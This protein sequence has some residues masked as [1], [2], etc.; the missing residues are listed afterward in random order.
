[1]SR[2]A[3]LPEV[4]V[5][6][7]FCVSALRAEVV[8]VGRVV[9]ENNAALGSATVS[10]VAAG[11]P[12]AAAVRAVCDPTGVFTLNLP[13]PGCYLVTIEKEG[14]FRLEH[15]AI[16]LSEG[17]NEFS[18]TLNRVREL[19]ESVDVVA[20][21]PPIDFDRASPQQSVTGTEIL[22]APYPN[23][24][25]LKNA[26]RIVPGV[27]Q[28]PSGRLHQHGGD[29]NQTLYILDGFNISDPLTGMFDT[30]LSVEGVQSVDVASGSYSA[31]YGKGSVGTISITTP[32]GSDRLR[33]SATNF[34]PG[35]E[36]S[37]GVYIGNWTPR[38]NLSGPI[39]K[40]RAWFSD[41][42]DLQ[43]DQH[44]VR[45]LPEGQDR[46]ASWR[47]SNLISTQVN[48]GPSN[49]LHAGFLVNFWT[50][51]LSGLSPLDPPETTVDR[52]SRQWF[53]YV[54]DHQYF[55][56]GAMLEA[57][58][59]ANRTF[60]RE[61]PQGS[62]LYVLLPDGKRGNYF[63]DAV[64]QGSRDQWIVNGF[65]PSFHL[66]GQH[67]VKAGLDF[68]WL[69][70]YQD[71]HRT[72]F[73]QYR[74]DSSVSRRVTFAGSGELFRSNFEA[75]SYVQDSWR[76]RPRLLVELGL[77]QDWDQLRRKN[78]VSPRLGVAWQPP[79]LENTKVSASYAMLYGAT[80]L[81]LFTRHMAKY[82]FSTYFDRAGEVVR[83]PTLNYFTIDNDRLR[84]PTDRHWNVSLEQR[85]PWDFYARA[86]Y[87]RRRQDNAFTYW[88]ELQGTSTS[89]VQCVNGTECEVEGVFN[90]TN[91]RKDKYD[92]VEM[93]LRK[94][95]RGQ[96]TWMGSY[97]WSRAR[98]NSAAD[99]NIDDPI[100]YSDTLGPMPWDTPNRTISW[101]Y[102]PLPWKNWA[103]AYLLE[104]RDGFPFTAHDDDGNSVGGVNSM[105]FPDYFELNVHLERTFVLLNYRWA[106]RGGVNNITDHQNPITVISNIDSPRYLTYYGGSP[107]SFNFRFR[108]LG[109]K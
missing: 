69:E 93:T 9:D 44:V 42:F 81:R 60:G 66:G 37:K 52:R 31:Q 101:G 48:L 17:R 90:L 82:S 106:L 80:N 77:R 94:T 21:L 98:S 46:T 97:T 1:V 27:V 71:A 61:I 105:R 39:R 38:V 20:S 51:P 18:F 102:F 7:A 73:E 24:H 50:F 103:L 36:T 47:F 35:V 40:G 85:L 92:A 96:Y 57:G 33:Y 67:Q 87:L 11:G 89:A 2:L 91:S 83:G 64:R 86:S 68:N 75:S 45:E 63:V 99:I 23:T 4:V 56:R 76:L 62:G 78:N 26:M 107:R 74:A 72:G 3:R 41:S 58:Y 5:W 14:F 53:A 108:W 104:W 95:F 88:N 49:V 29:E 13:G 10:L 22:N 16:E 55:G 30:R 65:L 34:I 100:R 59:A 6:C 84:S 8:L 15:Q 19:F 79:G 54:K 12:A 43:Y 28:D 109:K 25:S 32:M 70:Y